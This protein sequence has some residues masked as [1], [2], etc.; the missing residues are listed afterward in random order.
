MEAYLFE[1]IDALNLLNI[2]NIILIITIEIATEGKN[3]KR[4]AAVAAIPA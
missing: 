1:I 2:K 3:K 4:S